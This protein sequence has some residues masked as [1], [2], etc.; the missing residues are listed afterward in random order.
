M[1]K[2][3]IIISGVIGWEISANDI[4]DQLS[5]IGENEALEV[6]INTP[7]GSVFEGIEISNMI[8]NHKGHVT[9]IITGLAASMGS[10]I[11]LS[12]DHVTA[13]DDATYMIHNASTIAWGDHRELRK[14]A[15]VVES[16]T[17]LLSK[18]YV[19]KTGREISEIRSEMDNETWFFGEEIKTAG[20]VDEI[21]CTEE[22]EG[23]IDAMA[24]QR[25]VFEDS[26]KRQ[27]KEKAENDINKLAAYFTAQV[28]APDK[29]KV[30]V[31]AKTP[32]KVPETETPKEAN[33]MGLTEFLAKNP[34]AQAEYTAMIDKSI[35]DHKA[36]AKA[37]RKET[38]EKVGKI[39]M[40]DAYGTA[41]KNAGIKVLSGEKEYSNFEDLVALADE[42][43]EKEK[44]K[45]VV[46][47]QPEKTTAEGNDGEQTPEAKNKEAAEALKKHLG[48]N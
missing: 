34:E 24:Y 35:A 37:E 17:S 45:A 7:G 44:T 38:A 40:S 8:K 29:P 6:E 3:K 43:T 48:G 22:P 42:F 33:K 11:A 9:T 31:Q 27:T 18:A 36:T 1:A 15:N 23:Q 32:D 21:I 39:I 25:L 5:E 12:G 14:N 13:N 26:I 10:Y 2:K 4:R 47:D 16:L 19:K 41:I 20:F 28:P 30:I 46:K